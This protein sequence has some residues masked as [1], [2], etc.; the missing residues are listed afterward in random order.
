MNRAIENNDSGSDTDEDIFYFSSALEVGSTFLKIL[1]FNDEEIVFRY[2][3]ARPT[4]KSDKKSMASRLYLEN[5]TEK[6]TLAYMV[7]TSSPLFKVYPD[8]GFLRPGD[9]IY[10]DIDGEN[11]VSHLF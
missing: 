1:P 5:I 3:R 10:V 6:A 8:K 2:N 4:N 7:W 11:V 9:H